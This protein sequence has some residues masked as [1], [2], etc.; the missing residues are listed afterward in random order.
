MSEWLL[1][2]AAAVLALS[3]VPGLF[4]SRTGPTGQWVS[5]CLIA[6]GSLVGLVGVGVYWATGD[7]P[8]VVLPSFVPTMCQYR[9]GFSRSVPKEIPSAR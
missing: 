6:V 8:G 5:T 1:L 4:L 9:V 2:S 3:G 7:G